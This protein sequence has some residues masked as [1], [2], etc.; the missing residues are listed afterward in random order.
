[1][2]IYLD[3]DGVI[4]DF[5]GG[6]AKLN[7]KKHWKEVDDVETKIDEL[8][9]TDFF[10][11]LELYPDSK[12]LVEFVKSFGDDWGICSSPLRGDHKNSAYWKK[13]WLDDNGFIPPKK[14]HLVFTSNKAKW[15]TTDGKPNILIDDKPENIDKWIANGGIGIRYQANED[16][17]AKVKTAVLDSKMIP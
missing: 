17:I 11:T 6:F 3:M 9:K 1:M 14:E 12:E 7:G 8:A 2:V 4:A 5:F 13:V 10:G 16:T 15:A